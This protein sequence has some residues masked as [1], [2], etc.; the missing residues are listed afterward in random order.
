MSVLT[1]NINTFRD[2][3]LKEVLTAEE[4]I[5]REESFLFVSRLLDKHISF[6]IA[7]NNYLPGMSAEDI[8]QELL[9]QLM[10]VMIPRLTQRKDANGNITMTK[11]VNTD[12]DDKTIYLWLCYTLT[13]KYFRMVR[14]IY[15]HSKKLKIKNNINPEASENLEGQEFINPLD[16]AFYSLSFLN[17]EDDEKAEERYCVSDKFDWEKRLFTDLQISSLMGSVDEQGRKILAM[18]LE[19]G[20]G[21]KQ[22]FKDI[23]KIGEARNAMQ[24]LKQLLRAEYGITTRRTKTN[25]RYSSTQQSAEENLYQRR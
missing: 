5:K 8:K 19:V 22:N 25:K 20:Y 17:E 6:L 16:N 14:S 13:H 9:L 3:S 11:G 21:D 7:R 15:S 4:K 12:L 1:S 2:L 18:A 10:D 23:V 24:Q